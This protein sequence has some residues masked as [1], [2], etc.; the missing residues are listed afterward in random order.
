MN[1]FAYNCRV[2][3]SWN[4][5]N[6]IIDEEVND[7]S[8]ECCLAW[9]ARWFVKTNELYDSSSIFWGRGGFDESLWK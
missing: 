1:I 4:W 6:L 9:K 5:K 3:L 2:Y 8:I 7:V